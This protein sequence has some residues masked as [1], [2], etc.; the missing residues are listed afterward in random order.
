MTLHASNQGSSGRGARLGGDVFLTGATGFLGVHLLREL[1][2]QTDA[3]VSVLVRGASEHAA[4]A[5]LARQL[6]WY[7]RDFSLASLEGR[8]RV[9]LGDLEAAKLGLDGRTWDEL[10]GS[11][12]TIVN[13]AADV[14]HVGA[15]SRAFRINTEAVAVLLD[16]AKQG[17][18]KVFHHVS[19]ASVQGEF[20]DPAPLAAFKETHLEEGQV[21][22]GAY[23][24][25]KYR[26]EV[27][28]RRAFED[29]LGGAVYRVGYVG[30]HSV[31]G[32]YQR[33]IHQSNTARYVRACVR[34]GFAPYLPEETV[35]LTP[36]DSVA[37]AIVRLMT[38]GANQGKTYYIDSPQQISLYDV[39]R[40][41]HAAGYPLRLL[42]VDTFVEKA[43]RLSNDTES[44]TVIA[45]STATEGPHPIPT[46]TTWSQR[47]LA[48]VG[49]EYPLLDGAW[50]GRFLQH[51]IE[52]GFVEAPRFWNV[53]PVLADILR[54]GQ[55]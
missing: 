21:F 20:K 13:A 17:C 31:T 49:F 1:V 29:G 33:N 6:D 41:L 44:L 8:V 42:D 12:G 15:A 34:L 43:T 10:A 22:S 7:F 27:L 53:A 48:K 16:L 46:D 45:P 19:T 37:G 32:Q 36:V 38:R 9:V 25:S 50:L 51:A 23:P 5:A 14:N 39:Q 52:V 54:G 3:T 55:G 26:A 2:E 28:M 30:P 47:E 24:E 11:L 18:E 4:R 40:V 35:Q